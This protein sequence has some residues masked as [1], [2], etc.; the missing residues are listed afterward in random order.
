MKM[1]LRVKLAL[2]FSQEFFHFLP[3]DVLCLRQTD[4]FICIR[5]NFSIAW[6]Q[7]WI[8]PWKFVILLF[9]KI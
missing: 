8:C 6:G 1:T 3:H 2:S 5:R 4:N 7:Y 9:I